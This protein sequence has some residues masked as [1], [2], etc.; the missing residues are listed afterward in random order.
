MADKNKSKGAIISSGGWLSRQGHGRPR[1]RRMGRIAFLLLLFVG[2]AVTWLCRIDGVPT[3]QEH[4]IL[5]RIG[6]ILAWLV[7]LID[8][9]LWISAGILGLREPSGDFEEMTPNPNVDPGKLY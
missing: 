4:P 3:Q 9:A 2:V 6:D 8:L 1:S 5:L 7:I